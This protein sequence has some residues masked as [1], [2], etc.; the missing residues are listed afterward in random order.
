MQ[1]KVVGMTGVTV[2]VG[3]PPLAGQLPPE[4]AEMVPLRPAT[5]GLPE[6][7]PQP[8]A[9]KVVSAVVHVWLRSLCTVI[10]T[11]HVLP[12]GA[13]HWQAVQSRVSVTFW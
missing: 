5:G 1:Q 6:R 2:P 8:P 10:E 12:V 9:L 3:W 13:P 4:G 7:L 11:L